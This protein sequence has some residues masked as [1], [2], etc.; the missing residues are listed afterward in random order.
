MA[1]RF[2]CR[3]G[4]HALVR[5]GEGLRRLYFAAP[6]DPA[7]LDQNIA[8]MRKGMSDHLMPPRYLLEKAAAAKHAIA[9]EAPEKSH[10]AGHFFKFPASIPATD[11]KRLREAGIAAV[12]DSMLPAYV[13]FTAFIRDEYAPKGRSEPGIWA[14]PDG[15]AR[16]RFDVRQ[17]TTTDL[18]PEEIH[19]IGL[20]QVDEIEA[21]MLPSRTTWLQ[22]FGQPE[23]AH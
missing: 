3:D 2:P 22:G 8:Q 4:E 12:K 18:T 7:L 17:M 1:S 21:E 19:K 6:A 13:R 11:Q 23:R 20:K 16:Y 14:L 10:F 9:I 15:A 5:I